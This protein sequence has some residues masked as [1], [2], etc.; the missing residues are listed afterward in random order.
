MSAVSSPINARCTS[1]MEVFNGLNFWAEETFSKYYSAETPS[2]FGRMV[3]RKLEE[4]RS[5]TSSGT[6]R[7]SFD[8]M[9]PDG[10]SFAVEDQTFVFFGDKTTR[11]VDCTFVIRA[12][13]AHVKFGD[14]KEEP[15]RSVLHH[16]SQLPRALWSTQPEASARKRFGVSIPLGQRRWNN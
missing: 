11:T 14:T 4:I 6:V 3:F 8:L 1:H 7:A 2:H 5:G 15:S 13:G 10:N 16:S 12:L 9:G